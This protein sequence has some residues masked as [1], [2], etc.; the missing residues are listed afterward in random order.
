VVGVVLSGVYKLQNLKS[1][2]DDGVAI[3]W[4]H[5]LTPLRDFL[6]GAT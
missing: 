1:A 3:F 6:T 4:E 2:Q 5:D